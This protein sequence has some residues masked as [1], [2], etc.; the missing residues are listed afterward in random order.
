VKCSE[1]HY[2]PAARSTD[3]A[4]ACAAAKLLLELGVGAIA[5]QASSERN[6]I[7]TSEDE[8]WFPLIPVQCI[9][10]TGAG[11]HWQPR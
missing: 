11:M 4:S 6:L 9:D 10:A 5:T 8:Y 3:R 7:V 2:L 1:K